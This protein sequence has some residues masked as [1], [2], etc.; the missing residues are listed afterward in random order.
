M[1]GTTA[2]GWTLY[3]ATLLL[4]WPSQKR[5]SRATPSTFH[6]IISVLSFFRFIPRTCWTTQ[7]C[8]RN[9]GK[10]FLLWECLVLSLK[11]NWREWELLSFWT[12]TKKLL[13]STTTGYLGNSCLLLSSSGLHHRRARCLQPI[14]KCHPSNNFFPKALSAVLLGISPMSGYSKALFKQKYCRTCR[15]QRRWGSNQLGC[16]SLVMRSRGT[17]WK[18]TCNLSI[19]NNWT[20]WMK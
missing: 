11:L 15:S 13:G 3:L 12:P 17:G 14:S 18:K 20:S 6:L 2:I 1:Y 7:I 10:T 9:K 5:K 16:F 4:N 19:W 8:L